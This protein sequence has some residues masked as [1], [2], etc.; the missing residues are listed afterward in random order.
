MIRDEVSISLETYTT[1]LDKENLGEPHATLGGGELWYSPDERRG[2]DVRVLGELRR[3]GLVEGTRVSDD[4]MDVLAI[5]QRAS[6]EYYTFAQVVGSPVTIRTAALGRDAIVIKR[7]A[8]TITVAPIPAEQLSVR[9]AAALP[10]TPAAQVHSMSCDRAD[11]EAIV[12]D[13]T[14]Q[15]SASVRDAKRMKRWL[16]ME[17]INAGQLYAGVR[18]GLGSRRSTQSPVPT[19]FDTESGR[20]ILSPSA[21]GWFNLTGADMMTVV[22]KLEDLEKELRG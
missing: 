21:N 6:V 1:L 4:F 14:P 20:V 19:W 7:M 9:L 13:K 18:D 8:A 5:M 10:E 3:Q 11:F 12:K 22:G 16:E 17:R 15:Q 2:R